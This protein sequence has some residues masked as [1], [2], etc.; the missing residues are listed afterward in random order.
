MVVVPP[1][2]LVIDATSLGKGDVGSRVEFAQVDPPRGL[3]HPLL[4]RETAGIRRQRRALGGHI[5][6][7]D[8][9]GPRVALREKS[10]APC[11]DRGVEARAVRGEGDAQTLMSTAL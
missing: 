9:P 4:V 7:R 10:A 11:R 2:E 8:R 6:D 5:E 1:L 3:V